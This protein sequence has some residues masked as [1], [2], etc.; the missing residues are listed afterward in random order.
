MCIAIVKRAEGTVTK[1]RLRECFSR[2][3]DGAGFAFVRNGVVVISKGHMDFES[4]YTTYEAAVAE[5]KDSV[6]LIH[7]RIGT[8][9]D[10][11]PVNTHPFLIAEGAIIHNGVLFNPVGTRSDT[12]LFAEELRQRLKSKQDFWI[13]KKMIEDL[14]GKG[15]K[16]AMLF[17]DG[18]YMICNEERGDWIDDVWYS[19][20][21]SFSS[22]SNWS[23]TSGNQSRRMMSLNHHHGSRSIN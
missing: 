14:V 10:K 19:N 20:T 13:N 12:N 11:T 7:F 16:L 6:F 8:S 18:T 23:G 3:R 5:N 9:G 21:Y 1:D 15:N 2:N 4:F 22:S 17:R